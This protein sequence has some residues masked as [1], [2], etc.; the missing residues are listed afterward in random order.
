MKSLRKLFNNYD[1]DLRI[2]YKPI[3]I[4]NTIMVRVNKLVADGYK[5]GIV[6]SFKCNE[7]NRFDRLANFFFKTDLN[8]TNETLEIKGS[9]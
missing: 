2:G 6:Y 4:V 5:Q 8:N 9:I 7:C 1:S 3:K